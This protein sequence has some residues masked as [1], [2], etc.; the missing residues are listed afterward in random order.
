MS[1]TCGTPAAPGAEVLDTAALLARL[2]GDR[3][4][5][6]ELVQLFLEDCPTWL[7]TIRASI[8]EG[9]AHGLKQAAH[10]VRR[11]VSHF[12][13]PA[14]AEAARRLEAMGQ[15]GDLTGA[16]NAWAALEEAINQ[17]VRALVGLGM[18]ETAP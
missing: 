18:R 17:V 2:D 12:G 8:H 7:D 3:A 4:L 1:E 15:R 14:A 6:A 5:L 13:A 11:S 10:I 16:A 9:N